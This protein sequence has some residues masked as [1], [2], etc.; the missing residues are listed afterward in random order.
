MK[1]SGPLS[2]PLE[3]AEERFGNLRSQGCTSIDFS[4]AWESLEGEGRGI[5]DESFLA[6]LRKLLITAEKNGIA[7]ILDPLQEGIPAWALEKKTGEESTGN[8]LLEHYT[9]A[10]RHCY[11]RLKNC[12]ALAGWGAAGKTLDDFFDEING[13]PEA[14][15]G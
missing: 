6:Y 14:P 5:Y 3:E 10:F 12:R 13:P 9:A 15:K 2:F 4:I 11:R 7:V 1:I 8:R